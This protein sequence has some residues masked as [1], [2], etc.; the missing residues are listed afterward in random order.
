MEKN[1]IIIYF[2]CELFLKH[3]AFSE[4]ESTTASH[5]IFIRPDLNGSIFIFR[6]LLADAQRL[7][8][9]NLQH[10][11]WLRLVPAVALASRLDFLIQ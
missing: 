10:I 5:A 6:E 8:I 7:G 2:P 3:S 4:C 11:I 9:R 1:K